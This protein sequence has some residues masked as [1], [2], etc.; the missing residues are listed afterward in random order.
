MI[1]RAIISGL[2]S[3]GINVS[4]CS[5]LPVPVLRYYIRTSKEVSGG[6][7]VRLNPE[8]GRIVE[9]RLIDKNGQDMPRN[10][11]RKI[12]ALFFREDFRRA[13]ADD[14]GSI[15][16][17]DDAVSRYC[18][19]YLEQVDVARVRNA[20]FRLVVDYCHGPAASVLPGL[21][22]SLGCEVL[23]INA[24]APD[25]LPG[26]PTGADLAENLRRVGAITATL[27]M[28]L[29]VV[30][31]STGETMQLTDGQGN[32]VPPM[33]AFA[34]LVALAFQQQEG[35]AVA[36]PVTASHVLESIAAHHGGAIVR[37]KA[38]PQALMAA[39]D[40][41]FGGDGE[42]GFIVPRFQPTFD[43]MMGL[44]KALELL[45]VTQTT[46]AQ[47]VRALPSYF[48]GITDVPCAW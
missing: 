17:A 20:R 11:E 12:E 6:V 26:G 41:R 2:P 13:Q 32:S 21:L 1:K 43:A 42:G 33:A 27:G 47:A 29:G 16:Y 23:A 8:D 44:A 36:A 18:Q 48:M 35:L 34:A 25:N 14:I 4:D 5:S 9:A 40:V 31:D 15:A 46:L 3:A 22:D 38:D 10:A 7:H 37:T 24:T 39:R 19:G 28:D 30:I 45:A